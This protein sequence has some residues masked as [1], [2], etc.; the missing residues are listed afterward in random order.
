MLSSRTIEYV[1]KLHSMDSF[2]FIYEICNIAALCVYKITFMNQKG[3]IKVQ[4][5]WITQVKGKKRT[6][7]FGCETWGSKCALVKMLK[8]NL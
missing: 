2:S 4:C 1:R 5:T 6:V 3:F 8:P 7:L